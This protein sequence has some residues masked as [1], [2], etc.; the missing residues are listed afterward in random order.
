MHAKYNKVLEKNAIRCWLLREKQICTYFKS[1]QFIL[2]QIL[3]VEF[4]SEWCLLKYSSHLPLSFIWIKI[5]LDISSVLPSTD[6]NDALY[7]LIF[8]RLSIWHFILKETE[9]LIKFNEFLHER[10][11][12]SGWNTCSSFRYCSETKLASW[13]LA[14][15][16]V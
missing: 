7:M 14:L 13:G 5:L 6:R 4:V 9:I 2:I 8:W 11:Y 10:Q 16:V 1:P 3:C 15:K 12:F